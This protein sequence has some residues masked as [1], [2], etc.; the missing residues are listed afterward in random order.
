MR[1]L[2]DLLKAGD[3]P[4]VREGASRTNIIINA[5]GPETFTYRGLVEQIGQIIGQSRPIVSVP[6]GLGYLAS[7]V[8][9]WF[10]N[11]I[12]I[13]REEITG[14][15]ANTLFV[16]TPPTG[17]TKLTDWSREHRNELGRRYASEL[18]RRKN[19]NAAYDKQTVR[20]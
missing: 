4:S 1:Y 17:T 15:M 2:R 3:L 11:D 13:T 8:I 16:A 9:G 18:A 14:L 12:F 6:P 19:R 10:V 7:R 20:I 5:I